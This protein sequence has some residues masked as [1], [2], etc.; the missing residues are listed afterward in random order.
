[1]RLL[2]GLALAIV[3]LMACQGLADEKKE[4]SGTY[5]HKA[6]ELEFKVAFKKDSKLDFHAALGDASC[7]LKCK[8]T[9]EK[10]VLKCEVLEFEKKGDFPIT[11]EKGYKFEFKVEIKDS[12]ANISDFA[13]DDVSEEAKRAVEGEYKSVKE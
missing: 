6:D 11:K 10:G 12:K 7:V 2:S 8:Y 13:G 3:G 9:N 4:L 5:S 1:M